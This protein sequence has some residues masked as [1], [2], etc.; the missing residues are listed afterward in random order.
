MSDPEPI[1]G[2][3]QFRA[4]VA[5]AV[6]GEDALNRDAMAGIDTPDAAEEAGGRRRTLV[7]QLLGVREAAVIVH[8]H[9]DTVPVQAV[10]AVTLPATID[11]VP[12][13]D[14]IRPSTFV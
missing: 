10:V 11:P 7:G 3:R 14:R 6:V 13:T 12:A 1:A 5:A 4:G 2:G 8:R 9:M